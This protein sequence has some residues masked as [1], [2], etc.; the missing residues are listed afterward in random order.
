MKANVGGMD[1]TV[2]MV[3]GISL[4]LVVIFVE[5][6]WRWVGLAGFIPLL[7]G[8]TRWCPLYTVLGINTRQKEASHV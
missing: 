1:Q 6:G 4:L 8:I 7:T 5:S 3:A 2:R